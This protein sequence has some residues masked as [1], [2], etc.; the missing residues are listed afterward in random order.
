MSQRLCILSYV[1][2]ALP[3]GLAAG[4]GRRRP[5]AMPWRRAP[6][7]DGLRFPAAE[8]LCMRP[9]CVGCGVWVSFWGIPF[10]SLAPSWFIV[11]LLYDN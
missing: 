5:R 1:T 11:T 6:P 10:C 9:S 8:R 2:G 4:E 7:R 3:P